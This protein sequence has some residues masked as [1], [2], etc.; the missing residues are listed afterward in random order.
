MSFSWVRRMASVLLLVLAASPVHAADSKPAG[1][2]DWLRK[3]T[4]DDMRRFY[5]EKA[6][7][8]QVAGRAIIDCDIDA[9]GR[10]KNCRSVD[11]TPPAYG[12][13]A[14]ALKL[15]EIF[16]LDPKTVDANDPTRNRIVIPIV[17]G[18]PGQTIPDNHYQAGNGAWAMKIG[19]KPGSRGARA[20]GTQDKLDQWCSDHVLT[21]KEQPWLGATLPALEG[22]DMTTGVS[23]LLCSVSA[24]ARLVDC[25]VTP[26]ASPIAR[27][28]MLNLAP[29]FLAPERAE[30]MTPVGQGPVAIPFD[31]SRIT[32]MVRALKRP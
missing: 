14:A 13:G 10:L 17:F 31:W 2:L 22:V 7:R 30:D 32:P 1:R 16:R 19:V 23:T 25:A 20:C 18:M 6:Q 11:E 29:L 15:G 26:D 3:P 28:A 12:F 24:D 4:G 21:W 9:T 5:P 8:D 27:K